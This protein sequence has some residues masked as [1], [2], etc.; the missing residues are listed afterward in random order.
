MSSSDCSD[1]NGNENINIDQEAQAITNELV[2]RKSTSA[3]HLCYQNF[4]KWKT[5]KNIKD[6]SENIK[7]FLVDAS[8]DIYLAMK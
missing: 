3:Y 4:L 5:Q 2:A 6:I 7:I 8:D 1:S